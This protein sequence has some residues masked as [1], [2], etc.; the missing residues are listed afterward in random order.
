MSSFEFRLYFTLSVFHLVSFF[1]SLKPINNWKKIVSTA[2][3][4][5]QSNKTN[6]NDFCF[7][8][9]FCVVI[10][11]RFSVSINHCSIILRRYQFTHSQITSYERFKCLNK[12]YI[13]I[14]CVVGSLFSIWYYFIEFHAIFLFFLLSISV[15]LWCFLLE[16]KQA[17][18]T[19]PNF[20]AS[21]R[22]TQRVKKTNGVLSFTK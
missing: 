21:R 8:Y 14:I 13:L 10:S 18:W 11:A 3:W 5:F 20:Q 12:P 9:L 2:L 19:E 16:L 7:D 22:H 15:G 17:R 4:L 6:R 1:L